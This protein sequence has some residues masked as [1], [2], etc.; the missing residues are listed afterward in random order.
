MNSP[1][2]I[3]FWDDFY[4]DGCVPEGE[5][6]ETH[7][8]VESPY[9]MPDSIKYTILQELSQ[10]I[11]KQHSHLIEGVN[12]CLSGT[13]RY[14]NEYT[15]RLVFDNITHKQLEALVEQ[16]EKSITWARIISES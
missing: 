15:W 14:G 8:Y 13:R 4:D 9:Q 10:H 5:I 16:L 3:N 6:Q 7:A 11:N 2:V 1:I 12:I